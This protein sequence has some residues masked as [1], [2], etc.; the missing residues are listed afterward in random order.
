M[1][2]AV[3]VPALADQ[4]RELDYLVPPALDGEVRIGS[5]VRVPMHGRRVAAW[6]VE[7]NVEPPEGIALSPLARVSG[8]GPGPDIVELTGWG[9]WRW[10]G[11]R[12][13]LLRAASPTGMVRSLPPRAVRRPGPVVG[14]EVGDMA[15]EALDAGEAVIRLP[16]AAD[17]QPLVEA[18]A[19]AGPVVIACPS[20][21]DAR[22]FRGAL[23]LP[24]GW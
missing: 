20:V 17:A 7:D 14:G 1:R 18:L 22:R 5:M 16:P 6:V 3:D 11:R 15:R 19:G 9:A 21:E 12:T 13:A 24:A 4:R 2:V 8:I 10:A 23:T